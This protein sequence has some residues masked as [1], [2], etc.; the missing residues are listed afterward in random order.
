MK[1]FGRA[2]GVDD[3]WLVAGV[4]VGRD[5]LRG[6]RI[7]ACD[8]DGRNI[9]Q[10]CRE[11]RGDEF[12]EEDARR[13]EHLAAEVAALL[14]ARELI[15]EVHGGR[16]GLDQRFHQLESVERTAESGLPVRDDRREPV[17]M[18]FTDSRL[19]LVLPNK[20]VVHAAH[21]IRDAVRGIEAL[22]GIHLPRFVRPTLPADPSSTLISTYLMLPC[23]PMAGPR[24]PGAR[25]ARVVIAHPWGPPLWVL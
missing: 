10:I 11:A 7:R 18:R 5:E 19:L 16:A 20:G 22:V 2:L 12:L 24:S 4:D 1:A 15:F 6:I 23:K 9:A 8:Q 13:D 21:D 3:E 14:R 17:H 25:R